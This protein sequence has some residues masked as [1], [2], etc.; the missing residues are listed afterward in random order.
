MLEI[1]MMNVLYLPLS[2]FNLEILLRGNEQCSLS[3]CC[4]RQ[5]E[6]IVSNL[7]K[8]IQPLLS[9]VRLQTLFCLISGHTVFPLSYAVYVHYLILPTESFLLQILVN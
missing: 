1:L 5:K 3:L 7:V 2:H 4:P 8:D 9:E 6:E